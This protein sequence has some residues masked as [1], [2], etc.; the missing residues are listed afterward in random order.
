M[1]DE[2]G[3][4]AV[5]GTAE[6]RASPLLGARALLE[7]ADEIVGTGPGFAGCAEVQPETTA[8]AAVAAQRI[9][10]ADRCRGRC[11]RML[12]FTIISVGRALA[13]LCHRDMARHDGKSA[14]VSLNA[15]AP[16]FRHARP[17]GDRA[18]VAGRLNE[19]ARPRLVDWRGRLR[20]RTVPW[21]LLAGCWWQF[22]PG[23]RTAELPA[24]IRLPSRPPTT[25]RCRPRPRR[26]SDAAGR[27][28]PTAV[29]RCRAEPRSD[30]RLARRRR[31]T[32]CRSPRCGCCN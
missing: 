20:R 30:S 10:R 17:C 32:A 1:P 7:A 4:E 23:A 27:R 2:A 21:R 26:P 18:R 29:E 31:P 13:P 12:L 28:R 8:S 25:R 3:S 14:E 11:D 5:P 15:A 22:S 6:L 19:S 16:P 9:R 24:P